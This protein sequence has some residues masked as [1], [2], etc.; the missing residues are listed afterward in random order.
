MEK[1]DIIRALEDSNVFD[2]MSN[3]WWKI[4]KE[5]LKDIAK[6]LDYAIYEMIS[7]LEYD[8]IQNDT[9]DN[10]KNI[11]EEDLTNI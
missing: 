1:I 4:E 3:N 7:R 11:W 8:K 10:L 6:E 5:D 9:V 2:F